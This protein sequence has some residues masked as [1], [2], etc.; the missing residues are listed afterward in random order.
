MAAPLAVFSAAPRKKMFPEQ[1]EGGI[2]SATNLG[3]REPTKRC[4]LEHAWLWQQQSRW[5]LP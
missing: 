4:L 1:S 3:R 5:R 2:G